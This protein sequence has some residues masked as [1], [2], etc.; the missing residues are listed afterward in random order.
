MKKL[1]T[2]ILALTIVFAL[3]C[4]VFANEDVENFL[5]ED[6]KWDKGTATKGT[7]TVDADGVVTATGITAAWAAP[8]IDI[9]PSI[10]DAIGTDD[11]IELTISFEARATF[12]AGNEGSA[13]SGRVLMRGT[14]GI[15]GLGGADN[16]ESW[17]EAYEESLD[18]EDALF[19]NSKGNI[20]KFLG[21]NVDLVDDDWSV[22]T[23]TLFLYAAQIDNPSVT[24]WKLTL[25]NISEPEKIE[26][27]QFRNLIITTEEL[28]IEEEEDETEEP[29]ENDAPATDENPAT[30]RT[31]AT[32]ENPATE[33]EPEATQKPAVST[34][35]LSATEAPQGAGAV[36]FN[37]I[38][39]LIASI[40]SAV[41]II[42]A[43]IVAI[44]VV[45]K[46]T[47]K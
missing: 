16:V 12:T 5:R 4:P 11:E 35:D 19:Q 29:A 25:D 47:S 46:Q 6:A 14:N 27:L 1:L 34:P 41:I 42:A 38:A 28:E 36:S 26:N 39:V 43:C 40:V 13:S 33:N 24:E 22:Y 23:V 37:K 7:V 30:D 18:G 31:P 15:S 45:K 9:L 21:G 3:A 44:A 8:S 2:I 32:D 17:V 20:M 10:K